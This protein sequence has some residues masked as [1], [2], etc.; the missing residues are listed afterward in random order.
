MLLASSCSI[1][2]LLQHNLVIVVWSRSWPSLF[3]SMLVCAGLGI[4]VVAF[5]SSW[6]KF[7]VP[8]VYSSLL[9]TTVINNDLDLINDFA[10]FFIIPVFLIA[11]HII[12]N[13]WKDLERR[14]IMGFGDKCIRPGSIPAIQ[15][16]LNFSP[17]KEIITSFFILISQL[18]S[19]LQRENL[20]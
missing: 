9:L 19:F 10:V 2:F 14:S 17:R 3:S 18:S 5:I 16:D 7:D 15:P 12:V 6:L 1:S 4:S 20:P 11:T 8:K 13:S